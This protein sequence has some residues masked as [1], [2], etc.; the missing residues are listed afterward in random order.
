MSLI[1]RRLRQS[2]RMRIRTDGRRNGASPAWPEA[3][4]VSSPGTSEDVAMLMAYEKG[5]ES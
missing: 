1:S 2:L 4:A 5:A 3:H